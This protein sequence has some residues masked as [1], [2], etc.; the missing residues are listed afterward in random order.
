MHHWTP[1]NVSVL[2]FGNI[3][4]KIQKYGR[5]N[6]YL[7]PPGFFKVQFLVFNAE[8]LRN[9]TRKFNMCE[10][11]RQIATNAKIYGFREFTEFVIFV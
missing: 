4:H 6:H 1:C 3:S 8:K 10:K 7:F 9:L 2:L 5:T 11:S